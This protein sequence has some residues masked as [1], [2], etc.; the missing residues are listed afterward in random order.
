MSKEDTLHDC[1]LNWWRNLAQSEKD[2]I[3]TGVFKEVHREE[4]SYAEIYPC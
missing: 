4:M 2:M 1:A 3:I